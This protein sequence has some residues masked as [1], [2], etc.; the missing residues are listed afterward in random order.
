[1]AAP[2]K[3]VRIVANWYAL[4]ISCLG[5][6]WMQRWFD[7]PFSG[8]VRAFLGGVCD[9]ISAALAKESA[10]WGFTSR[11]SASTAWPGTVHR[12]KCHRF[13]YSLRKTLPG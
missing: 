6:A 13:L 10:I 4:L 1:M 9:E 3:R 7:T 5:P 8:L 11:M 2:T 12:W